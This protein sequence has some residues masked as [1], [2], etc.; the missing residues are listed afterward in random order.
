MSVVKQVAKKLKS[1]AKPVI[2]KAFAAVQAQRKAKGDRWWASIHH[3]TDLVEM[4]KPE[5]GIV[6]AEQGKG[7]FL[8]H[9]LLLPGS[10]RSISWTKRGVEAAARDSLR[11]LWSWECGATGR[12]CPLPLELIGELIQ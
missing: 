6:R 9:H 8:L 11:Q 12:D 5:N 2:P 7:R 3:D 4:F 1:H 10:H